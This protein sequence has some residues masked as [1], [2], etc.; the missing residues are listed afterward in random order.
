ML[1]GKIKLNQIFVI[2]LMGTVTDKVQLKVINVARPY[3]EMDIFQ[4]LLIEFIPKMPIFAT[5]LTGKNA[6]SG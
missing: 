3:I 5:G 1:G 6:R 2:I 4:V